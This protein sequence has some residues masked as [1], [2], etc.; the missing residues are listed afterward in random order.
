[1]TSDNLPDAHSPRQH[2]PSANEDITLLGMEESLN[3]NIA[4]NMADNM[5][6]NMVDSVT[7]PLVHRPRIAQPAV[8]ANTEDEASNGNPYIESDSSDDKNGFTMVSRPKSHGS[9]SPDE[10]MSSPELI[11]TP[12]IDILKVTGSDYSDEDEYIML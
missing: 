11:P 12:V 1:M 7:A 4:E 8:T 6:E 2:E 9:V 5:F 3:H 10:P